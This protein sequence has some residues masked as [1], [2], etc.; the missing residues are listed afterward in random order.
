M[1]EKQLNDR[2]GRTGA[3]GGGIDGSECCERRGEN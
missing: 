3:N 2:L 1:K